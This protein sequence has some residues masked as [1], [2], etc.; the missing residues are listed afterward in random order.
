MKLTIRTPVIVLLSFTTTVLTAC[1]TEPKPAS[2]MLSSKT[3][4]SEIHAEGV[5]GGV[6]TAV[7][8]MTAKISAIDYKKRTVTLEDDKGNRRTLVVGPEAVNFEQIKKGDVLKVTYVEETVVYLR[9]KGAPANDGAGVV[10]A[11]SA[12]GEKPAGV[13][14]ATNEITAIVKA[15]DLKAHTATLKFPDGSSKTVAVRPDVDLSK[16]KTGEEVV[17]NI[18]AAIAIAVQ[19]P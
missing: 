17:I 3:N 9:K 10:A 12:P 8:E 11:R 19:K 13:I 4:V 5:P 1:A 14:A 16:A 2:D 6:N 7:T 15:V 18:T